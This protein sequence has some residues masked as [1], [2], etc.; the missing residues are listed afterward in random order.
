MQTKGR[1]EKYYYWARRVG[2]SY[3]GWLQIDQIPIASVEE[4][5]LQQPKLLNSLVQSIAG[6][7]YQSWAL[8]SP[9]QSMKDHQCCPLPVKASRLWTVTE[10]NSN[11]LSSPSS[12]THTHPPLHCIPHCGGNPSCSL[13]NWLIIQSVKFQS[14]LYQHNIPH[15]KASKCS[16]QQQESRES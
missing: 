12:N 6:V 2:G 15:T 1:E 5:V 11:A 14:S 16:Q 9:P 8:I 3:S 13:R 10:W 4:V 7:R